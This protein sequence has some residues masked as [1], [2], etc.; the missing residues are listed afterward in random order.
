[1]KNKDSDKVVVVSSDQR[2]L[3]PVGMK[4]FISGSIYEVVDAFRQDN[5]EM[6]EV[7][8]DN[9]TVEIVMVSTLIKDSKDPTFKV[10]KD[11]KKKG[12]S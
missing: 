2:E 6:R 3:F 8:Q 4:Y 7:K 12:D 9:G 11:L 1:M 10:I 5:T